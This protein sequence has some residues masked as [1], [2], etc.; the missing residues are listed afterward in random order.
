MRI[1]TENG[2]QDIARIW[3]IC[4]H[5]ARIAH[6]YNNAFRH[7]FSN[8][9]INQQ[10][11]YHSQLFHQRIPWK[12][13]PSGRKALNQVIL[14]QIQGGRND[15]Q[16]AAMIICAFTPNIKRIKKYR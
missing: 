4:E 5:L 15:F 1:A 13:H 2:R 12:R 14:G 9:L 11:S 3:E 8:G 6:S 10:Y 7:G 16:T